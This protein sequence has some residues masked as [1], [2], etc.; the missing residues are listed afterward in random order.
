MGIIK[1]GASLKG[2]LHPQKLKLVED[3]KELFAEGLAKGGSAIT[4]KLKLS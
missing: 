1:L 4:K 2:K 3:R